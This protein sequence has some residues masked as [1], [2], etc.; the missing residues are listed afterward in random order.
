M[1]I[2]ENNQWA[3][4]VPAHKSRPAAETMAAEGGQAYGIPG[5]RVDGNDVLA[6]YR[7]CKEA[8]DRARKG[9]GPTMV[10]TVTY[11][12]ASHS[13]VRRRQIATAIK[14]EYER[15]AAARP[16]PAG[17]R[18]TSSTAR[19]LERGSWQEEIET[20]E[21]KAEDQRR[22]QG[23]AEKPLASRRSESMFEDVY[24]NPIAPTRGAQERGTPEHSKARPSDDLGEFPL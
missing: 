10:E 12:M 23:R 18:S 14:E 2:C 1:F 7:V 3:I 19:S 20:E 13:L 9:E 5:V 17:S 16:D 15:V 21:F 6:V 11:R 8:I 22:D 4:S 24:M